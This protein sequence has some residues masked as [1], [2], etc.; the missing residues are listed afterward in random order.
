MAMLVVGYRL[1]NDVATRQVTALVTETGT[2]YRAHGLYGKHAQI[3]KPEPSVA[4]L[5][6]VRAGENPLARPIAD[7]R[8]HHVTYTK[9]G[10]TRALIPPAAVRLDLD[11]D[12]LRTVDSHH[13]LFEAFTGAAPHIPPLLDEAIREFRTALGLASRPANVPWSPRARA[14]PPRVEAMLRTLAHGSQI[15][16]P[17][18]L[19]VG[20]T[21]TGGHV[22]LH[23]GTTGESLDRQAVIEL[24]AALSAWL[25]FTKN[26][27]RSS[28]GSRIGQHLR[29]LVRPPGRGGR[30]C[31][32]TATA[33]NGPSAHRTGPL[34][35]LS[36]RTVLGR[37]LG[38]IP[39]R[40]WMGE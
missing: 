31:C 33:A 9:K 37:R 27:V 11:E 3:S 24:Q 7:L 18:R 32:S 21:V 20:W 38:W 4:L 17:A 29:R 40:Q 1:A 19:P 34:P 14:L 23:V 39:Q 25:H 22:R 10:F 15:S 16:S 13:E 8:T 36:A 30:T 6:P 28:P 26:T 5:S 2:M 35:G 12:A